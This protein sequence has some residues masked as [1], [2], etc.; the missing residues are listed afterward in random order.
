MRDSIISLARISPCQNYPTAVDELTKRRTTKL[1]QIME[2]AQNIT[3]QTI[4]HRQQLHVTTR[5]IIIFICAAT[6][7][8]T[9]DKNVCTKQY[10]IKIGK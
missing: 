10:E 4:F 5:K 2:I 1:Q 9:F 6:Q 3:A 7:E 8:T